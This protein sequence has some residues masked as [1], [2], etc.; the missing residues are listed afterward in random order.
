MN[1]RK[2]EPVEGIELQ[3][4]ECRETLKEKKNYKYSGILEADTVKQGDM[5]ET[6]RKEDFKQSRKLLETKLSSTHLIK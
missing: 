5:K 1:S 2:I 6:I 4:Q 3:N